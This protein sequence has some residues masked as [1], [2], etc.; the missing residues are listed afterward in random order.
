MAPKRNKEADPPAKGKRP[1][2]RE[3]ED[4]EEEPAVSASAGVK[5]TARRAE[6]FLFD[7]P[8][9]RSRLSGAGPRTSRPCQPMEGA[10]PPHFPPD[11][12]AGPLHDTGSGKEAIPAARA[13]RDGCVGS[14]GF[15][16]AS[17]SSL[18]HVQDQ[19]PLCHRPSCPPQTPNSSRSSQRL[20][21]GC[22]SSTTPLLARPARGTAAAWSRSHPGRRYTCPPGLRLSLCSSP[23]G[24]RR[25]YVGIVN[26]TADDPSKLATGYKPEELIFFR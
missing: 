8:P 14:T 22:T 15:A 3:E 18:L 10:R 25:R 13:E 2:R 12:D 7:D 23:P 17:L 16:F 1:R 19:A 11:A 6:A 20:A 9:E 24:C 21:A 26:R 5:R 4:E